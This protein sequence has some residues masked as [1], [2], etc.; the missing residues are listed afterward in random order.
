MGHVEGRGLGKNLQGI[1]NP[2]EAQARKGK[3]TIGFYGAERPK[4]RHAKVLDQDEQ[5]EVEIK[6][7]LRQWKKTDV[8]AFSCIPFDMCWG[9][10]IL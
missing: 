5:E 2:V 8:G 3:A 6:E 7:K 9:K 4:S 10:I 1:V